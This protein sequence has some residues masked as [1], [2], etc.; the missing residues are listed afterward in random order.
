MSGRLQRPE[1]DWRRPDYR[2]VYAYREELLRRVQQAPGEFETLKEF[3]SSSGTGWTEFIQDW[4]FTS[5]PRK[6]GTKADVRVPFLLFPR[7]VEFVQW[8]HERWAR[9]ERGLA[10]KSREVGLSWLSMACAVIVWLFYD[11]ANVGVGSRKKEFVDNGNA[12][13]KSLFWKARALIKHL[14]AIWRPE[15]YPNSQSKWGV[16]VN[17]ENS[18]TITGEIG[19]NIGMGDRATLYFVDEADALE[20]PMAAEASLVATTDCRIDVSTTNAVGTVFY[21]NR[22]SLPE[23]QVFAFDWKED[24][25]KRQHPHLPAEQEPWYI[26]KKGETPGPVFAA[27]YERNP[28]AAQANSFIESELVTLPQKR[29]ELAIEQADDVPWH[30]GV[31]ASGQG[32]DECVLWA[33]RGR[34]NRRPVT[35]PKMDGVQLAERVKELAKLLLKSAPIA[36]VGIEQD[37]PGGSC[38]D[39][40]K[41]SFLGQVLVSVHTGAKLNDGKNYNLR[42][43][44]HQQA[45]DYLKDN[46]V[47]LPDD[48]T[49]LA[50]ATAIQ[51]TYKGGLLLIESK[52]D[53]RARMSGARTTMGKKAGRSPDRWDGFMLTFLPPTGKP[54]ESEATNIWFNPLQQPGWQPL[55]AVMNY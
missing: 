20:H 29:R 9:Q 53:Y 6:A 50:Q 30:I 22:R 11:E 54:V 47:S 49:F 34:I 27:Q 38:A 52:D 28:A 45:K 32:A 15:G 5:D 23:R 26:K 44:A 1:I 4:M 55:D 21:N 48:P 2:P 46:E 10:E 42:A 17:P 8:V 14:P 43:W 13:Q 36:L 40:L 12:D 39:N 18:S 7:Q 3:Y 41:Y 33:R 35:Y 37:G 25:R 31:D 19:D 51:F 16:I 24:P